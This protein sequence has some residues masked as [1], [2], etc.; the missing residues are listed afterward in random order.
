MWYVIGLLAAFSVGTVCGA[1]LALHHLRAR[2]D[3][4]ES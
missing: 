1:R 3:W 4:L 2:T